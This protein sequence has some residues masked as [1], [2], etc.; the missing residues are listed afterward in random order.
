KKDKICYLCHTLE[1]F[2]NLSLKYSNKYGD[3]YDY[4]GICPACNEEHKEDNVKGLW[5]DGNYHGEKT[6]RLY[7]R[8]ITFSGILIV[9]VKR[10]PKRN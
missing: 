4:S 2:N 9:N 3:Y 5:G 1:Q 6:Y 8:K 7:C 10:K